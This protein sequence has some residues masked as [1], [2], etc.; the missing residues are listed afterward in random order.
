[1][2]KSYVKYTLWIL[3]GFAFIGSWTGT[4]M[5]YGLVPLGVPMGIYVAIVLPLEYPIVIGPVYIVGISLAYCLPRI[6]RPP[7]DQN[8]IGSLIH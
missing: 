2:G 1:M 6:G 5:S 8:D 3:L 4:V 7:V